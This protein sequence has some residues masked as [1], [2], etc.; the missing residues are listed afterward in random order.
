MSAISS[1]KD[2]NRHDVCRGKDCKKKFFEFLKE[3]MIK[4]INFKKKKMKLLAYEHQEYIK[5]QYSVISVRK[6][7][8]INM[9]KIKNIVK[10]EIIIMIQVNIELLPIAYEI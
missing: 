3:N 1:F 9:L 7:S 4:I 6:D 10:L 2:K 8:Q 5:M